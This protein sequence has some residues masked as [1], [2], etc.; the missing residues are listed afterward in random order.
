M[1][2]LLFFVL[3]LLYAS[4][5]LAITYQIRMTNNTPYPLS[6]EN[7]AFKADD[8][9]LNGCHAANRWPIGTV[10]Q[11][12]E[13]K[14]MDLVFDENDYK[15]FCYL[16]LI[17]F[18]TLGFGPNPGYTYQYKLGNNKEGIPVGFEKFGGMDLALDVYWVEDNL[19]GGHPRLESYLLYNYSKEPKY[20]FF[21]PRETSDW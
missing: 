8:I 20:P 14:F 4:S 19:D 9:G 7:M 13:T 15:K 3:P 1:K 5:G 11:E 18:K 21:L 10:L 6:I 12:G 2:K 17:R 16:D